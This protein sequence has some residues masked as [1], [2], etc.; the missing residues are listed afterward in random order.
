VSSRQNIPLS[1]NVA[2]GYLILSV[3]LC[4]WPGEPRT[5]PALCL[6][7]GIKALPGSF[8]VGDHFVFNRDSAR[9]AFDYVDF[10][11]QVCYAPALEEIKNAQIKWED[12]ALNQIQDLD[13]K[14]LDLYKKIRPGR[15]IS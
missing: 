3:E 2:A 1:L 15:L 9:W 13:Q 11:A 7:A 4:G 5:L 8:R 6:Y 14:A 10:H 12:G